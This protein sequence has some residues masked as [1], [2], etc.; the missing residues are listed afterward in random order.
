M[1]LGPFVRRT[2]PLGL[3]FDATGGQLNGAL[4]ALI[5]AER[6][7]IKQLESRKG[8]E[9]QRMK[10]FQEF[11]G[12]FANFD[13]TLAELSNPNK[14]KEFKIDLGDGANAMAV[15][16]DKD[17][18]QA[19]SYDI[20][21]ASLAKRSSI[22]SNGF[23]DPNEAALG[24]G[25][26]VVY[27]SKG[28]K[29]EVYIGGKNSSLSGIATAINAKA[30][31]AV[32]ATVVKDSSD[33]D[34]P[35]RLIVSAKKDGI[36]DEVVFPQFYFLDGKKD[37]RIDR[38]NEAINAVLKVD[39]FEIES[40]GNKIPDFLT[41][42]N[43]ELKQAKEGQTYTVNISEDVSKMGGKLKALVDQVNGIFEF[44]T[45]QNTV[46][47]KTDTSAGFTGDTSLQ[48]V[49]YRIRNLMHEGFP[50]WDNPN[51]PDT[52]RVK[53]LSEIGIEFDKK[54]QLT[55]SEEKFTKAMQKDAY[56]T[57]QAISGEYGFASQVRSVMA[58][59]TRPG[60]G[61]LA[62]RETSLKNRI[63]RIDRDIEAKERVLQRKQESLTARFSAMQSTMSGMQQQQQYL[64]AAL[65]GGGGN[66][67][68][69]LLGG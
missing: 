36:D 16:V 54:G 8:K 39:G 50:I 20:E 25:Y 22:I 3:R 67:I 62:T 17:K 69:Q 29:E 37:L 12:K 13:R 63:T 35:W 6:Q 64:S 33:P 46:D 9:E 47:D 68:T 52:P 38:D 4:K 14:F 24:V 26:V 11:K 40:D 65:G 55:Y 31:S 23:T 49:E 2:L 28:D 56:G 45:K 51:D 66:P 59:Y 57:A 7:P 27:N 34:A 10:T 30:D 21:I 48:S 60:N 42:V 61:L 41:G 19:G 5:E 1:S 15:T 32:K 53:V 44:I 58:N 43:L 18:V